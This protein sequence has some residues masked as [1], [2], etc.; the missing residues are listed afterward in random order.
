[1]KK[2]FV[3]FILVSSI[4]FAQTAGNSGLSFLKYGFGA[5][6]AALADLGVVLANDVTAL[7]YNPALLAGQ[8]IQIHLSHNQSIQDVR[9]EMFGFGFNFGSIN[10]AVGINTTTVD[11]I[12][13]RNVPGEVLSKFNANYFYGSFSTGFYVADNVSAGATIKYL[14]EGMLTDEATGFGFDFG[15]AYGNLIPNLNLGLSLR[16]LGSMNKLREQETALPQDL[17]FGSS[18][19]IPV[20]EIKSEVTLAAGF[21]K[22]LKDDNTHFGIATDIKYD[23]LISF[24]VGYIT[25]YESKGL[26]T[27]FGVEWNGFE[28]DYAYTPFTYDLGDSH[29]ISLLYNF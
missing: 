11:D 15:L 22:F 16:N 17:R 5:R 21:N 20:N 10:F 27:G 23:K 29:L 18:Y 26:T 14:Y 19:L 3:F 7:N 12:E 2:L 28:V 1:M 8:D 9:S 24:R 25:G 4:M 6:N 13:I